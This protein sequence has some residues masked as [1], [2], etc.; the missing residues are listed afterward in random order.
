LAAALV[1][2][3]AAATDFTSATLREPVLEPALV[4]SG[5]AL[6]AGFLAGRFVMIAVRADPVARLKKGAR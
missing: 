1:L 6:S 2:V 4:A 5:G 3:A